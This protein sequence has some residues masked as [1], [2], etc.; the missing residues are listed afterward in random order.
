[1]FD[2]VSSGKIKIITN[3]LIVGMGT[4]IPRIQ[5]VIC[6][7]AT[8]SIARWV[9]AVGRALRPYDGQECAYIIDHGGMC[10]DQNMG[11]V[12]DIVDWS[13]E[14]KEKIQDRA[15]KAKQERKEPKEIECI[16]CKM[17]F[18]SR[19][20]CPSCGYVMKQESEKLEFYE[21][22]LAEV[23][24][25]KKRNIAKINRETSPEEKEAFFGGLKQYAKSKGYSMGW[26]A[27]AYKEKFGV[28]PNKYKD[29]RMCEPNQ[30]VR[31]W[32]RYKQIQFAKRRVA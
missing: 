17:I 21:A 26:A 31:N 13:L 7:T 20:D 4:D 24:K 11:P 23:K 25:G 27:H 3:V 2:D 6:A 29:A 18:K 15:L 30:E 32:I 5:T 12:E 16:N 1:M 8:K 22:D 19:R 10:I 14:V 28:W 9:Q